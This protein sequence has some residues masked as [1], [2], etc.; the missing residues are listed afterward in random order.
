MKE[1]VKKGLAYL[2]SSVLF[3]STFATMLPQ[4]ALTVNAEGTQKAIQLVSGGVANNIEG[5]Q[6]S[7]VYFGTYPQSKGE[8]G[9]NQDPIKWRVLSNSGGKLFL[10]SDKNLDVVQYHFI[11][12]VAVTWEGSSI[13]SWLN[14]YDIS[15]ITSEDEYKDYNK[16]NFICTAFNNAEQSALIEVVVENANITNG[17][18]NTNDKVYLLS[19]DEATNTVYGFT[20]ND[21]PTDKR[22][23]E[24]T[25]YVAAGG[26]NKIKMLD[27]GK[28]DF[29][30]LRSPGSSDGY[31]ANVDG[32]GFVDRDGYRVYNSVIA[33]R[34]ALNINLKSLIFT[35]AAEGG[36]ISGT[37]GADAL[38]AVA[39]YSGN[40]WKLTL[41]DDGSTDSVGDGHKGFT[42]TRIN[43]GKTFVGDTISIDY[44]NAACGTGEYISAFIVDSSDNVLFYGNIADKSDNVKDGKVDF[45]VPEGL[46]SG[47]YTVKIFSEKC[48]GDKL[49]DYASAFSSFPIEVVDIA[50]TAFTIYKDNSFPAGEYA[51]KVNKMYY[52][53]DR[54]LT[55][56]DPSRD[57]L[58]VTRDGYGNV[59]AGSSITIS[60]KNATIGTKE[61]ITSG[62]E[63]LSAV[64][65]KKDR[66]EKILYYGNIVDLTDVSSSSSGTA[67]VNIPA[68]LKEGDYILKFFSEQC[69]GD[70]LSDY[71]SAFDDK[72]TVSFMVGKD[73]NEY[74]NT[75]KAIQMYSD[76]L[77]INMNS[78][79]ND[80]PILYFDSYNNGTETS[81][82]WYVI[83][84]GPH[85]AASADGKMTLLAKES[86]GES[87]FD[88]SKNEYYNSSLYKF[89]SGSNG[90]EG[91]LTK[92]EE[93]AV[94]P[95]MLTGGS[96][97]YDD[98]GF[99]ANNDSGFNA[100][101][102]RGNSVKALM[103][104][105]SCG[106]ADLTSK[107][108]SKIYDSWWLRSPGYS[109][110][111]ASDV[112]FSGEFFSFATDVY[113]DYCVR[114]ALNINLESIIFTSAAKDGKISGK[115]AAAL[116]PVG[117]YDNG[118]E[119]K[120]TIRDYINNRENLKV[121]LKDSNSNEFVLG[122]EIEFKYENAFVGKNEYISAM[123]FEKDGNIPL[124]YG[125]IVDL[126]DSSA[127][128]SGEASF[129]IPE[130]LTPGEYELKFYSEQYNGDY[131]TDVASGFSEL[132]TID[133][134]VKKGEPASKDFKIT[135]PDSELADITYNGDRK[136]VIV[137]PLVNGMGPVKVVYIDENNRKSETAPT[138]AGTYKFKIVTEDGN[139]YNGGTVED[140]SFK[141]TIE[142]RTPTVDDFDVD[143]PKESDYDG[144]EREATAALIQDLEGIGNI[145]VVYY[146]DGVAIEGKPKDA[147]EYTFKLN[148]DDSGKN[149]NSAENLSKE[150]WK[151]TINKATP[152]TSDFKVDIPSDTTYDGNEK[153]VTIT[154][155]PEGIGEYSVTY[156]G[157]D[158]KPLT[159]KPKDNGKYKVKISFA[160]GDNFYGKDDL[161]SD[162]WNFT[163]G[164]ATPKASD[165][166][167]TVPDQDCTY[168][169]NVKEA[170][171][172]LNSL[173]GIGTFDVVYYDD[174]DNKLE[175]APKE[176]GTYKVKINVSDGTN[177]ES[178]VLDNNW[179]FTIKTTDYKVELDIDGGT[180]LNNNVESYTY[181]EG[182]KLPTA[183]DLKKDGHTF[184]GWYETKD[185]SG[186]KVTVI[187][188]NESG[189]K[190]YFAKWIINKYTVKFMN[191][192]EV[193]ESKEYEYG[194]MPSYDGTPSKDNV[195]NKTY[196]FT[197]WDPTISKVTGDAT[198]TAQFGEDEI[199]Y[200]ITFE[201]NGGSYDMISAIT[202]SQ[203]KL[204]T[205]PEPVLEGYKF[206]GWFSSV[207]NSKITT[208][209]VF[210][211]DTNIYAK[212]EKITE[213]VNPGEGNPEEPEEPETSPNYLDELF[214]KL[215]I[216][217][218]LGGKQEVYW[219]VGDSLPY[220]VLHFL[221]LHE[222]ITLIFDYTYEDVDYSVTLGGK[223]FEADP[224]VPWAGPLYLYS[225]YKGK[226][227]AKED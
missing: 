119:W 172:K 79:P 171:V 222:D 15:N 130:D 151:F 188:D 217:A 42:A 11:K 10:L 37:A 195:D 167:V 219:N 9:F 184:D 208:E 40:D 73:E 193:L 163:I 112:Y 154:G 26:K 178:V 96:G 214:L 110:T 211:A 182:A 213:P 143:T 186:D 133:F 1:K 57:G 122:S 201:A 103:W 91:R 29:W 92:Y 113:L 61:K 90:L 98:L 88:S 109:D 31:A 62:V 181:G 35:S 41:L 202:N 18:N 223:G 99:Y 140:E 162:S 194:S 221:E 51:L 100:N 148:V 47:N 14:G 111:D 216:A 58:E 75:G 170:S 25:A 176:P 34:P 50:F 84:Y 120:I 190:K 70:Y 6:K 124:Y 4:M 200:T 74:T 2:L 207:D 30:W 80:N 64:L 185:F 203:F 22:Q 56:H 39:D 152:S 144:N 16:D 81:D 157:S 20:D 225:V 127:A 136:S 126:P 53:T 180:V 191:G 141:F 66:P 12:K 192:D 158:E 87:I 107:D 164:K 138:D 183:E 55:I 117:K 125:R 32:D 189:E 204:D 114:P 197:G 146:K 132:R 168:D 54:E 159:G 17:G 68:D 161:E 198:Y 45:I 36:K 59:S 160:E 77:A 13:R 102:I 3:V 63:F 106:E 89:I 52:G 153:E 149:F 8:N 206:I 82:A 86:L 97:L 210:T 131:K 95:K 121:V 142:K 72:R 38:T 145:S 226:I 220:D 175:S 179:T 165:F 116:Q 33:I 5:A 212:W 78:T 23:S 24:N 135:L 93:K 215:N 147:G 101:N 69:N 118:K 105:L 60:Y 83:G 155:L 150:D 129:I 7:N 46:K 65:V 76:V 115:G 205:L 48:N 196:Y 177:Y 94:V 71:A 137:D 209:T 85:G 224:K 173:D 156:Y 43:S 19:T 166:D 128:S 134:S 49:T 139:C 123:L 174:K 227:I 44:K 104:P 27:E 67:Y 187:P 108:L 169:G 21:S 199:I 218:E 28:N